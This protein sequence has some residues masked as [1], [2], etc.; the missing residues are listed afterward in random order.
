MKFPKLSLLKKLLL[1]GLCALL[2]AVL[3]VV[4][5]Y[6]WFL[7]QGPSL[8]IWHEVHL[9]EEFTA[10]KGDEVETLADYL[11]LEDRLFDELEKKVYAKTS[12]GERFKLNRYQHGSLSDPT[13]YGVDYNRTFE[14][15]PPDAKGGV[16]LLHGLSDSPYSMV[17][18]A[19]LLHSKGL[20]VL[21]MRMPGHGTVPS[22][23]VHAKWQDLAAATKIGMR[24]LHKALVGGQPI[25][26][27]GYSTGAA[28]AVD[29]SLEALKDDS[30][31]RARS[32][33]LLSP[34]IGVS[35]AA[36]F[37]RW[38]S[39]LSW[40]LGMAK[41]GWTN[42]LP[43]YDP[44]KYGSFAVN[45]GD[46]IYQLSM[47]IGAKLDALPQD[48]GTRDFPPTLAFS[49]AVDATVLVTAVVDEFLSKVG[50]EGNEFVLFDINRLSEMEP[51]LAKDPRDALESLRE[52]PKRRFAFRLVTNRSRNSLD[53]VSLHCAPGSDAP[54][55]TDLGL[56]WPKGVHSL[57]HVSMPFPPDDPLYGDGSSRKQRLHLGNIEARG[58]NGVLNVPASG[59]L[60]LRH[61][62][63]FSFVEDRIVDFLGL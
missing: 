13:G 30:L 50:N 32:L 36:G 18:I 60:R 35:A 62:P 26:I 46:L 29:Y 45:A 16:L 12:G 37:A 2:G 44:Y 5:L 3:G 23:L 48:R 61:N 14:W 58:E 9:E 51:L 40:M 17:G 54:V 25:F 22:G 57:A 39:G 8:G 7:N 33:V 19:R 52:D 31:P 11:A 27:V 34:A 28:L 41:V 21:V 15:T 56:T 42:I 24:H 20:H 1:G 47:A 53:L 38:Q 55:R 43:E 10:D 6:V 4:A 49:S 63:F 59:I